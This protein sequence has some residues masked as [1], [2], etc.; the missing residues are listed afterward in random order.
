MA[1]QVNGMVCEV[2]IDTGAEITVVPEKFAMG[3]QYTGETLDL[4]GFNGSSEVSRLAEVNFCV[5]GHIFSQLVAVVP[6]DRLDYVLLSPDEDCIEIKWHR[7]EEKRVETQ[8]EKAV[9]PVTRHTAKQS[10]REGKQLISK[11]SGNVKVKEFDLYNDTLEEV[12]LSR[13]DGIHDNIVG[14]Q[15]EE[16]VS[17]TRDEVS[18]CLGGVE[19]DTARR[20]GRW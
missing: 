7:G 14:G 6:N 1:G 3:V 12:N 15:D 20:R 16:C 10:N 8:Q 5:N 9:R 19:L 11:D 2:L 13:G 18:S 17:G 4:K